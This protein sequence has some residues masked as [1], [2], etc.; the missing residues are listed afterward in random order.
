MRFPLAPGESRIRIPVGVCREP[1]AS[2]GPFRGLP[3][4]TGQVA[5]PPEAGA[6]PELPT[7]VCSLW[8]FWSLSSLAGR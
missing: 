2:A 3:S 4:P 6:H 7:V 8:G 1:Q 5:L